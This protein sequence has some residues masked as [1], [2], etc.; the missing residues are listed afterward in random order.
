MEPFRPER[1]ANASRFSSYERAGG[2]LTLTCAGLGA[3]AD[4]DLLWGSH[5][6]HTHSIGAV[7]FVALFAA[8][9]AVRAGLPVARVTLMCAAAYATHLLLDWLGADDFAPYGIRALWPFSDQWYISGLDWFR[10]TQRFFMT[11][12]EAI[13]SNAL[14]IG[15]ELLIMVPIVVAL[16]LIRVKAFARLASEMARG[17]H[18][19][20]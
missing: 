10:A 15:Q 8:A 14:A 20:Q 12:N 16:W 18:A 17:D 2:A 19:A 9:M 1:S 3:A 11:R 6:A 7:I 13:R 5:R 4:L